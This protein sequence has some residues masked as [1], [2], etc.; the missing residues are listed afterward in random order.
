MHYLND[1]AAIF[2]SIA[3][4]MPAD[5][6]TD[7][8]DIRAFFDELLGLTKGLVIVD[9]LD[10]ANWDIIEKYDLS[11]DGLLDLTWHDYR[12]KEERPEEKEVREFVFPGDRHALA[13][14]V[15]SIKPIAG[16]NI[17]IFLI[18]SYSKTEKEIKALYSKD[19]DEIHYE[20]GSFFEKRVL[21]RKSGVL[22]FIDFHC[23]PIYSLALIP[24]KTG[25]K[26]YDSRFI[27]YKF[28]CEQSLARL[29]KVSSTLHD[30]GLRDRDEISARVVTAR[31]VFEFVLKVECCYSG[32][33]VTKG[34]SGM[35][36]GDLI[37]VVK[38][39]KDEKARAELGRIAEL[40]NN[41]AHDT[42][43]PVSKEAAFEVVDLIKNY[44]QKL[45]AT[46]KK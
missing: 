42:G 30:P 3:D 43:K 16:P 45:H 33:E 11:D 41:F 19:A 4:K 32:L 46:I 13:L 6:I 24:K 18:N 14:Y 28:N 12:E 38:R 10:T 25:I 2:K 8:A 5:G 20:D 34:Y 21:R 31:R 44:V 37:A 29:E 22:E 35:L 9:F 26:S 23:T 27:L 39:G 15:D 7:K 17:A 1:S 36:L 40:A